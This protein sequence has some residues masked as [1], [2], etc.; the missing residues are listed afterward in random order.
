MQ[1]SG[2]GHPF[3]ILE[4]SSIAA[5]CL[6][7]RTQKVKPAA[8]PDLKLHND[9]HRPRYDTITKKGL[10]RGVASC[11]FKLDSLSAHYMHRQGEK[12]LGSLQVLSGL[13]AYTGQV[14]D[15]SPNS[16]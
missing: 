10:H 13:F 1:C 15:G 14:V 5:G 8:I 12:R 11:A 7:P 16:G 6:L 3:E 9:K 4:S 2:G